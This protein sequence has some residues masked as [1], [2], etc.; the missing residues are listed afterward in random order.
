MSPD[1]MDMYKYILLALEDKGEITNV[2]I[3]FLASRG[4]EREDIF[5]LLR[6]FEE[7]GLV[8]ADMKEGKAVLVSKS[9]LKKVLEQAKSVDP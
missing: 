3:D 5:A 2:D 6:F 7:M 1:Y 8:K 9:M 4:F